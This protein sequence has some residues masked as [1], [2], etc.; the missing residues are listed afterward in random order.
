MCDVMST[1][2]LCEVK[3]HSDDLMIQKYLQFR[4]QIPDFSRWFLHKSAS[5]RRNF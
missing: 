5:I 2:M 1:V 3:G 4:F